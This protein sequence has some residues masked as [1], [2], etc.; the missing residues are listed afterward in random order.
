MSRFDQ[1]MRSSADITSCGIFG[2]LSKQELYIDPASP[3]VVNTL[4]VVFISSHYKGQV[5]NTGRGG[6]RGSETFCAPPLQD[7]VRRFKG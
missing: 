7:I 2:R 4:S 3:L 5:I 6:N 1:N